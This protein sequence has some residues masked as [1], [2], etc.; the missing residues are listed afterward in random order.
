MEKNGIEIVETT[1]NKTEANN[2]INVN[3]EYLEDIELSKHESL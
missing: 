3:Q 2:T 1:P